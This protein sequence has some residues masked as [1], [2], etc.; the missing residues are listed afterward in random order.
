MP[1][2]IEEVVVDADLRR[3]EDVAEDPRDR[4]F[5]RTRGRHEYALVGDGQR[6]VDERLAIHLAVRRQRQ[7]R[8]EDERRRHHVIR[9][10]RARVLAELLRKQIPACPFVVARR[11]MLHWLQRHV[12][13]NAADVDERRGR[14]HRMLFDLDSEPVTRQQV[15]H[16]LHAVALPVVDLDDELPN[17]LPVLVLDAGQDV[18]LASF[19]VDFQQVDPL[20]ALFADDLRQRLHLA[21][22]PLWARADPPESPTASHRLRRAAD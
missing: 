22:Q 12:I 17:L 2:E 3:T 15:G 4:L 9:Q 1:A 18:Q 20:D 14:E 8:H 19:R 21:L 10:L 6:L 13:A 5:D 7:F 11:R 16:E